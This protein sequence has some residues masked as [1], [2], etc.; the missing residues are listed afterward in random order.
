MN[1]LFGTT[2]Q[3]NPGDEFILMGCINLLHKVIGDFNPIIYNRNPQTRAVVKWK[4]VK[5]FF[6]EKFFSGDEFLD[7]SFKDD[8]EVNYVDLVVFAGSP[9]WKGE[10]LRSLYDFIVKNNVPVI[11]IGLGS[12]KKFSFDE[13]FLTEKEM[14]VLSSALFLSCRDDV[15]FAGFDGKVN[16]RK[17]TCPALLS[18]KKNSV[19]EEVKKVG[20]IYGRSDAVNSNRVSEETYDYLM[21][22]YRKLIESYSGQYEFEFIAHYIDELPRFSEDFPGFKLNYSYD[23]KDYVDIFGKFDVVVGHRIHGIGLAASQGIP[24]VAISHDR[25]G[26]TAKGFGAEMISVGEDLDMAVDK[27]SRVISEVSARSEKIIFDKNA[28]MDEYVSILSD[29]LKEFNKKG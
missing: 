26:A 23:A 3:W 28:L 27:F 12:A 8:P 18:S 20:L 1:V 16:A 5:K 24:G 17:I 11:F 2:R 21:H 22:F 25:R 29:A 19:V 15:T 10:R 7:N 6:Y 14:S 4:G 13:R 9:E